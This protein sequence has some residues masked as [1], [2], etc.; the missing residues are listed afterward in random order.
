MLWRNLID[1]VM[2]CSERDVGCA[3]ATA[4]GGETVRIQ[5]EGWIPLERALKR[6]QCYACIVGGD[7]VVGGVIP[8]MSPSSPATT[9]KHIP[10]IA[11]FTPPST[12]THLPTDPD[13]DTPSTPHLSSPIQLGAEYVVTPTTD[14]TNEIAEELITLM[15]EFSAHPNRFVREA[16]CG[17]TES[18]LNLKGEELEV[19]GTTRTVLLT[20]LAVG[21]QDNWSQVRYRATH[22][23]QAFCRTQLRDDVD[24]VH[25]LLL[26]RICMNRYYVAEGVRSVT[27]AFWKE[28]VGQNGVILVG[29]HI[30]AVV[31]YYCAQIVEKNH[32]VREAACNCIA[33]LFKKMPQEETMKPYVTTLLD[34]ADGACE[35]PSWPVR[36]VAC[37]CVS[38]I[39]RRFPDS[40]S[41]EETSRGYARFLYQAEDAIPS[42]R[43]NAAS[44]LANFASISD[45]TLSK[46]LIDVKELL[47]KIHTQPESTQS[48]TDLSNVTTFGVAKQ[49]H[50]NDV[51][52]HT[53]KPMYGCGSL[54][55]GPSTARVL[56]ET[57][58]T[59]CSGGPGKARTDLDPWYATDTAVYAL[60]EL[61]CNGVPA[62]TL[63]PLLEAIP[64]TLRVKHFVAYPVYWKTVWRC[65][66]EIVAHCGKRPLSSW[67]SNLVHYLFEA[68][69]CDCRQAATAA[70]D[71]IIALK[72]TYG[73]TVWVSKLDPAQTRLMHH[74]LIK[75]A[76]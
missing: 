44:A 10:G 12:P 23:A 57:M 22:C 62:A 14:L 41:E 24:E 65:V 61:S 74:P 13:A 54:A 76:F 49:K 53:G 32:A 18:I 9:P 19:V 31:A 1:E 30:A 15:C 63:L 35:D 40:I 25:T 52:A 7:N 29:K 66:P 38:H 37:L 33:E 28:L 45:A 64:D 73:E 43:S 68:L 36:D 21:L 58:H 4:P 17:V 20:A 42:V 16:A 39:L 27:H 69:Q 55:P 51:A 60:R 70:A 11:Q 75:G 71:C 3:G 50:D 48:S 5:S 2:N 26:P 6:L 47:A 56:G 34:A 8:G 72:R 67:V 59:G 46:V